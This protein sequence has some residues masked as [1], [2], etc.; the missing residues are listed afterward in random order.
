MGALPFHWPPC[1]FVRCSSE[2]VGTS[3]LCQG[4]IL[5]MKNRLFEQKKL[6]NIFSSIQGSA[7]TCIP[8]F[9]LFWVIYVLLKTQI[10]SLF[11]AKWFPL[12]S[13]FWLGSDW[14]AAWSPGRPAWA[15]LGQPGSQEMHSHK[16][17]ERPKRAAAVTRDSASRGQP[18]INI[19]INILT[20][21]YPESLKIFEI[22]AQYSF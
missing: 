7:V 4:W 5:W 19:T 14:T 1:P 3:P 22:C 11:L 16:S 8:R 10:Y 6:I 12:L 15:S 18:W 9:L 2:V 20:K 17:G 13:T 21:K